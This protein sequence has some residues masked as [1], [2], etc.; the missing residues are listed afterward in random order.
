M[1][2][3]VLR[4]VPEESARILDVGCGGGELGVALKERNPDVHVTGITWSAEEAK[5][6][7]RR[8]DNVVVRNLDTDEIGPVGPV[9]CVICS[10]V[11]EHLRDPRSILLELGRILRADGSLVVAL[12]NVLHWRQ[13]L[14]FLK[15]EFRYTSGGLMDDT[16]VVFFDW[17]TARAMVE[18]SGFRILR[19]V[20][21]G[22]FPGSRFF[23][24]A[25]Q[26]IDRIGLKSAPGLFGW[27]FVFLA[28]PEI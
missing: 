16:H 17:E 8:L 28:R 22:A 21:D 3:T 10:H 2:Q 12:P 1:N 9:D 13:R 19:A 5:L 7:E 23:G 6:A 24:K 18:E 11:L 4:L 26:I 27:Q 20:P 14:A 15:G 25:G